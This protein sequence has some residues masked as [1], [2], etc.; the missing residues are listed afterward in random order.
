MLWSFFCRVGNKIHSFSREYRASF[1]NFHAATNLAKS[2]FQIDKN[3]NFQCA[4]GC[5]YLCLGVPSW[6]FYL[7]IRS[8]PFTWQKNYDHMIIIAEYSEFFN[9]S[10]CLWVHILVPWCAVI[11][12]LYS[13]SVMTFL[14]TLKLW[15]YDHH[16]RIFKILNFSMCLWVHILVP[17]G[18]NNKILYS[19]SVMTF[20]MTLKLWSY[21]L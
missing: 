4:F 18:A 1:L 19:N 10:M 20:L 13:N 21:D 11:K 6:K 17:M 5:T 3:P 16:R 8:C 7:V 15:S 12:I 9:F 2:E 14:M